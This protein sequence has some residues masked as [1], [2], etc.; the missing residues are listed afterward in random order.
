MERIRLGQ[1][2][3]IICC[4]FYLIWWGV[5][6]HPSHGDSHARGID[7]I[8]LLITAMAAIMSLFFYL[9]YYNVKPMTGYLFGM[10]PLVTEAVT[11]GIF[12]LLTR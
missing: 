10:V 2:F 8:L 3:L 7:G 6:F 1:A 11:M 12:E 9:R 4:I 5:A